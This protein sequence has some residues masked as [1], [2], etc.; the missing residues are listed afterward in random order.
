V[1]VPP[2][3]QALLATRLD[4]LDAAERRVLERGAVEGEIFHRGAV[5][6]LA[7]EE[8]QVTPQLAALVRKELILPNKPQLAGEDGFRFRHVLIRDAAYD[9]LTKAE[10]AD[11]HERFAVWLEEH[12]ADLVELDEILGYHFEQACS[13]RAELGMPTDGTLSAAARRR[14]TAAGRRALLRSDSAASVSL[15]ERATAF[16]APDELDLGLEAALVDALFSAGHGGD[17]L[18]RAGSLAERAST[19]G[20]RVGEL[21]GRIKEGVIRLSL[22][23]EGAADKLAELAAH[24]LPEFKAAGDDL[25]QYIAYAALGQVTLMHAQLAAAV[26]AFDNAFAHAQSAGLP[27]PIMQRASARLYGTTP[28]S[29]LLAWLDEQEGQGF[30]LRRLRAPALAMHGQVGKAQALL[31]ELRAEWSDR[32]GQLV[33]ATLQ[34]QESVFVELLAGDPSAAAELGEAGCRLLDEFGEKGFL[35]TSAGNLARAL[36]ALDRLEDADA[37][38]SRAAELGASD[39]TTTQMLW[40]QARAK[41]LARRGEVED[42]ERLARNAVAI[43]DATDMLDSQGDAYADLSDVLLLTGKLDEAAVALDQA[44]ERYE[45]KGNIV[46]AQRTRARLADIRAE[47]RASV[48]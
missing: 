10:R 37:W 14:L 13:Y 36:Y 4:Q 26:D 43:G 11:L 30:D 2:T 24:A 7:P 34:S 44:L 39:D 42:A 18:R 41:V 31:A 8:A 25:A 16:V 23:P 33:L 35:S 20:N 46:S 22:E 47:A 40:R 21:C 28:I 17:A 45:R 12:G 48:T 15:L 3:L 1:V 29:E 32:G 9:A 19:M 27:Y 6:A 38:A 5:Q